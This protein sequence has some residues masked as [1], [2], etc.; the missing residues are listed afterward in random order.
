MSRLVDFQNRL[1][2]RRCPEWLSPSQKQTYDRLRQL[3]SFQDTVNLYGP[4]GAG[5]TFLTWVLNQEISTCLY[6]ELSKL[7]GKATDQR[8]LTVV[9]PHPESRSIVRQT[10]STLHG[11]GYKKILLVSDEPV[12]DQIPSCQLALRDL[13]KVKIYQN[14]SEASIPV[15]DLP[16]SFKSMNLHQALREI[17]LQSLATPGS[18]RL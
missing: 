8:A 10:L 2:R 17:G 6:L 18:D 11:L 15:D 9:D 3:L 1:R 14:W 16:E 4:S 5:K 13:D 7:E 12:A